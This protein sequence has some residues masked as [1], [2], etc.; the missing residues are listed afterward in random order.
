M[1]ISLLESI[2]A[3]SRDFADEGHIGSDLGLFVNVDAIVSIYSDTFERSRLFF[4]QCTYSLIM[5]VSGFHREDLFV[6]LRFNM[7]TL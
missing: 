5:N 3:E 6:S 4:T 1:L 2:R 7:T